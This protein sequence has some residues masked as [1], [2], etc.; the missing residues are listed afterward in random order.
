MSNG[1]GWAW[2]GARWTERAEG[3]WWLW[4]SLFFFLK[5]L[6]SRVVFSLADVSQMT[7]GKPDA[8]MNHV[9][10]ATVTL[11]V[12]Q[13]VE[14][15]SEVPIGAADAGVEIPVD[16]NAWLFWHMLLTVAALLRAARA[17]LYKVTEPL[18]KH[19]LAEHGSVLVAELSKLKAVVDGLRSACRAKG[20][21]V[22]LRFLVEHREEDDTKTPK[23]RNKTRPDLL[24]S[25]AE[26][27]ALLD[28][29]RFNQK[30]VANAWLKCSCA[31]GGEVWLALSVLVMHYAVAEAFGRSG[32]CSLFVS[33]YRS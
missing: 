1:R 12:N 6:V 30:A 32:A 31:I 8:V 26:M 14:R 28:R 2:S 13:F 20:S 21:P 17:N 18:V 10:A 7:K 24:A 22:S 29:R 16:L 11:P 5:V 15:V 4:L 25:T 23:E 3:F 27:L 33:F 9:K 19:V